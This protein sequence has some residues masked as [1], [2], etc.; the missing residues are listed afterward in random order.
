MPSY[1]DGPA[2]LGDALSDG[3]NPSSDWVARVSAFN[4]LRNLLQQGPKGVQE[5]TQNFEK[6]MKLFFRHLDDPHHKVAQASLSTLAEII[7]AC[8]KMFESYLE[9]ILPYVFS[10]LIDPKEL[11]RQPCCTT[12]E[13]VGKTYSVDS[14]LP[15]LLR[16]LDEQRS[17]KAK[18]AVIDFANKSVNKH[19]TNSDG[20]SNSGFLKLW[21]AKLAPLINDKNTKLKEA[22]ISGIISVYTHF[23][24]AAVLNFILSLS[25]QEQNSLRR[26]LKQYTPR[27][28]VDL[29][30][31]L[32]S[33]R[34]R[35]RSKSLY[36]Q[37][38]V[39]GTS[40]EEGY[41]GSSK[42][43]HLL[44]RY[45]AGSVDSDGGR[46]WSS[47]QE[48][49]RMDTSIGLAT[50]DETKHPY[51]NLELDS[52]TNVLV[53]K[54][55]ELKCDANIALECSGTRTSYREKE[56]CSN[57]CDS[58]L[59]TPRL[60]IN[61]FVS[62]NGTRA[63]GL[64][65]S[66]ENMQDILMQEKLS[67]VNNNR[68][69]DIG[70]SIPQILHQICNDNNDNATLNKCEA[71]QQLVEASTVN[72]SAVWNKY[73]NQILTAVLEV[74]DDPDSSTR[75]LALS[76]IAGMIN[77]QKEAMED[78][79]EIVIEKLLHATKDLVPKV[80][81][82][83]NQCLSTILAQYNPFRCLAVIVP[84]LVSD[85]EK[86]L[87]V[88]INCLTKLVGRL[89]QEELMTQLPSFLP[90]V[91][92]AFRNQSPDVRKTV[93]FCLVDIYIMLG[94]A[95]LPYLEGLSSTQLRLVTMY[96]N[97]ISQARS[98]TTIDANHG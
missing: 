46:K 59:E 30:N 10:R 77:N 36:D 42:M 31:F 71:L 48:S 19:A 14:L 86:T 65:L 44:G 76:L 58:S 82:E 85:D 11:V 21:L 2:S 45:S 41:F 91:F 49:T 43:I 16:S 72:N 28:E 35:Q 38:D 3:L 81:N 39:G 18:L 60:D 98:G 13:I 24:S 12:L 74:L 69:E 95:F 79:V 57:E 8:R 25:I 68:Q 73:F 47:M 40:S 62:Y 27:I 61:R 4:Y 83:A 37:S 90:A 20:Y 97:R 7:P 50:S 5:V 17:P 94:K 51:H 89:S 53:H 23:D 96:A 33:K 22:S 88:C 34:E 67:S 9:R 75:E 64:T 78:S 80:S 87:V 63:S 29:M 93:V 26:A 66:D 1:M 70:P 15:A 84:L 52:D 6:V 92:D 55:R 32:Q 56:D 54:S